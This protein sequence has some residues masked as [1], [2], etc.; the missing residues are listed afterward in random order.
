MRTMKYSFLTFATLGFLTAAQATES[1]PSIQERIDR[2]EMELQN[3]RQET[4]KTAAQTE[5]LKGTKPSKETTQQKEIAP[6]PLK[7]TVDIPAPALKKL[8][9]PEQIESPSDNEFG[10]VDATPAPKLAKTE[11]DG[12]KD[13]SRA[14]EL[15]DQ[16]QVYISQ[17]RIQQAQPILE[18]IIQAYGDAPQYVPA[19]YWLGEIY[20]ARQDYLNASLSFGDIYMRHKSGAKLDPV[21]DHVA[22]SL[23]KLAYCLKMMKKKSQACVTLAQVDKDFKKL[24]RNITLLAQD[25]K[26]DLKCSKK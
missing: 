4:G 19:R 6:T 23:I 16:A 25:I 22:E 15:Y 9:R 12:D 10:E 21:K 17:K 26:D 2:L 24:P 18:E 7:K 20:Y 8:N 5:S 1:D 14:K 13:F 3:L 11:A